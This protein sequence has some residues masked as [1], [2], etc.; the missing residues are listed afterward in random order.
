[1]TSF[2]QHLDLNL[3]NNEQNL[4][5]GR[6]SR[7]ADILWKLKDVSRPILWLLFDRY[8]SMNC[9]Q[10]FHLNDQTIKVDLTNLQVYE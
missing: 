5:R 6:F 4:S 1:M 7:K 2:L 3:T 8:K 9:N 10:F